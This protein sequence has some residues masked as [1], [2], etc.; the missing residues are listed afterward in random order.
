MDWQQHYPQETFGPRSIPEELANSATHG[1]GLAA[2]VGA[3]IILVSAAARHGDAWQ[4]AGC[5]IYA[6]TLMAVYAAS[7]LSHV[8]HEPALKH[9]LRMLDQACIYLLIVGTFT[10]I[11]LTYFRSGWW[12]LL[13]GA[14]WT[15]ALAGFISKLF[16]AHRVEGVA[17]GLYVA[18]GWLPAMA[19]RPMLPLLPLGL[20]GWMLAGGVF[21]T[22][23]TFFL[24]YDERVP[25]F[26]ATWHLC[27]I[28]GSAC[29]FIAILWY[30]LPLAV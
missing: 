24:T 15:L 4:I 30:T 27:V 29:H 6:A 28:A 13:F 19:V 10:P 8:F 9:R 16:F 17:I 5:T 18:L 20:M 26:H 25:Y 21:Y 23:G 11:S 22:I 3:A 1:L 2:S 12:W 7:T 14:M